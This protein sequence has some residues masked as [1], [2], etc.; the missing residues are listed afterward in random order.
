[1]HEYKNR[2]MANGHEKMGR[3]QIEVLLIIII[4]SCKINLLKLIFQTNGIDYKLVQGCIDKST[5]EP[6]SYPLPKSTSLK[7]K[8]LS[9]KDGN[10]LCS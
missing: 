5:C 7:K 3:F 6:N 8:R 2:P 9:L 1:M 10:Q 4:T